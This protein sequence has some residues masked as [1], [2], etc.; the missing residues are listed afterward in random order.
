[1]PPRRKADPGAQLDLLGAASPPGAPE[2]L[3]PVDGY[4]CGDLEREA[5]RRGWGLLIGLDEAGRGPLAGPVVAAACCL[6][7]SRLDEA[8]ALGLDDSKR[9]DEPAREALFGWITAHAQAHAVAIVSAADIDA[10]NILRASLHA[11]RLAWDDVVAADPALAG[12]RV[13]VDGRDRAPLPDS[14]WQQPLIKGDGRS[15]HVAAASILAK[16]TRDRWMDEAHVRFP[17]YGFNRH[18]GYPTPAH[19]AAIAQHGPC[20]LH[21]QSFTLLPAVGAGSDGA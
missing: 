12:A 3:R 10:M 4:R 2:L 15:L 14:V 17:A 11:M 13:L 18:R 7:E 6:P 20:P 16:V 5:A 21:R 1:M 9:L 8:A 19:R